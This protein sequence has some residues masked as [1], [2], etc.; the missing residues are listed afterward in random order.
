MKTRTALA[1]VAN[2]AEQAGEK[3]GQQREDEKENKRWAKV[4]SG[5]K[6]GVLTAHDS[7]GGGGR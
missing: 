3:E 1:L 5:L 6:S 4:R 7:E 2:W